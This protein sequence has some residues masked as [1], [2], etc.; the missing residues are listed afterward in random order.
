MPAHWTPIAA[1]LLLILTANAV[2]A[3][4]GLLLGPARPIDGRH[5]GADRQPWLGRSKTWRGLGAA[6]LVTPLL[7]A[8]IGLSWWL[9]LL[10][11]TGAMAGDLLVSFVKR[12]LR[13]APS[14]SVPPLD[15]VPESLLPALLVREPLQLSWPDIAVLVALF[16]VLDL[17][18]T[19]IGHA[20]GRA[21]E[22]FARD[23]GAG[24]R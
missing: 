8:G 18:L 5:Q 2:P 12:R 1:V 9:G 23:P 22:R 21:W 6:L 20:L 15:Q 19:P 10:V 7:A 3:L 17:L 11:A 14:T 24:D 13:L 16:T 4:L